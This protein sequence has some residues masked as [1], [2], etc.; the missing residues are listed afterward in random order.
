MA[1]DRSPNY[2]AIGL[3][4]AIRLIRIF[5]NQEKRSSVQPDAAAKTF[6]Y[7][8]LSGPA[9]TKISA[10]KKY[11]LLAEDGGG[12]KITELGL[13]IAQYQP[14]T[15]EYIK[16]VQDAALK[17]ELFRAVFQTHGDASD[18]SLKSHLVV[19]MKFSEAGAKHF[20]KAFRDTIKV[21]NLSASSYNFSQDAEENGNMPNNEEQKRLNQPNTQQ[22]GIGQAG[23]MASNGKVFSWPLSK[24]VLAEVRLT[25]DEI[26]PSHIEMLREYLELAKRALET[27]D[28]SEP[29]PKFTELSTR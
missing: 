10:L 13:K 7:N 29:T 1:I 22:V 27:D 23:N 9:R 18:H 6:G 24:G 25:G 15:E 21:A 26:K 12:L 16:A 2:P 28:S 17:P 19:K 14:E 4:Q 3:G 5:W 11:G 8:S 20:I